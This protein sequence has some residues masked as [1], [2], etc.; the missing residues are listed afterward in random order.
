LYDDV[1]VVNRLSTLLATCFGIG[2]L[3]PA[4]GTIASLAAVGLAFPLVM[5]G[6]HLAL[7]AGTLVFTF[8]GIWA[9]DAEARHAG[10]KDPSHCVVD[11]LAGQW[12][13]LLPVA[14]YAAFSRLAPVATA[15]LLFRFFDIL[16]PFP[17]GR[18]EHLPGGVG[19][20]ADDVAAGVVSALLLWLFLAQNW[21]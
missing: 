12:L 4:P 11:E 15:F 6:G 7:L 8:A 18:F 16:K 5:L 13:A 21:I 20:M 10:L 14:A 17:I 2:H 9:C 19:V 1:A 3:W